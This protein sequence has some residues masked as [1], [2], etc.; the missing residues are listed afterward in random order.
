MLLYFKFN[1]KYNKYQQIKSISTKALWVPK[2]CKEVLRPKSLRTTGLGYIQSLTR[3]NSMKMS[4]IQNKT[5]KLKNTLI[6][7]K[8]VWDIN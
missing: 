1:F 5:E 3:L 6:N 8:I 2:D 7:L 4:K